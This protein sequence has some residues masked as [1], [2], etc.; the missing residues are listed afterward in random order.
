MHGAQWLVWGLEVKEEP[1][2]PEATLKSK[3]FKSPERSYFALLMMET[4]SSGSD[5]HH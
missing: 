3:V 4:E 5:Y 2:D 1:K